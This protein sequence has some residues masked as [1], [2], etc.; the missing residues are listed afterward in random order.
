MPKFTPTTVRRDS[1]A[2]AACGPYEALLF[3]DSG[4]LSQFGAFEEILPPGSASSIKHWHA[5]EDE[6]VYMIE[7]T[8]TVI[9]G[10]ETYLLHAGEAAT[11]KA[12]VATGHCLRN[13]TPA[14][15][16]YL[17]IGTRSTGDTV[18]YPDHDRI[19]RFTR[20][21]GATEV[22]ERRYSTL[23]GTPATTSPYDAPDER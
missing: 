4:G 10:D 6:M 3:S 1:G 5:A 9:E 8:A 20:A 16:R 11:F 21:P 14:P 13:D 17:V 12:G 22:S 23:D 18:T 2:T 7:G 19:L 15:I